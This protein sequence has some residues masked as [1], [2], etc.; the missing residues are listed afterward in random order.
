MKLNMITAHFESD[1]NIHRAVSVG[2]E[3]PPSLVVTH[4]KRKKE[5]AETGEAV[6]LQLEAKPVRQPAALIHTGVT[7]S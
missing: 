3:I 2:E 7:H 5:L 4:E 1:A 6:S